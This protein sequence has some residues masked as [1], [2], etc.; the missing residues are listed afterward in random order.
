MLEC[1]TQGGPFKNQDFTPSISLEIAD[2][3]Y[4]S[5]PVLSSNPTNPKTNA[6]MVLSARKS[7]KYE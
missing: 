7:R 5:N 6:E 1:S 2:K 4:L 3:A